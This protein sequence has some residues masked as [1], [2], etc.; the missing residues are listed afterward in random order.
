MKNVFE[1]ILEFQCMR[2]CCLDRI[3]RRLL[4]AV[5]TLF[6]I[7]PWSPVAM[8]ID[9]PAYKVIEETGNFQVR[10]YAAYLVA[11][12]RVDAGFEEAG[13]IGFR[14]LFDYISGNNEPQAKIEMTA[15]VTQSRGAKIK[16]TAPVSQTLESGHYLIAFVVPANYTLETVPRPLDPQVRIREVPAQRVA[17]WRY[18][19]RW[20]QDNYR[21]SV[22]TLREA[23]QARGLE[24]RG[25]PVLARYN[26][27]FT[28]WFMRRNEI[29][30][31]VERP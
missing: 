12:T 25:E 11:E 28:P 3:R 17:C 15:P 16:M 29:L 1:P 26:P 4:I 10:Q 19:G 6:G 7:F 9:E 2:R 13:N 31:P 8:A 23:L 14:R 30:I 22:A 24:E 5:A 18:S 20:T 21:R 27:P